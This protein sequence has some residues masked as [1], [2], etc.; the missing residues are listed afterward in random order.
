MKFAVLVSLFCS[1]AIA[2]EV[3]QVLKPGGETAPVKKRLADGS[4]LIPGGSRIP[5]T[6]LNSVS[7]KNTQPGDQ[8][9]LQTLVPIAI[10]NR[11][12]IPA[13]SYV[14]GTITDS[15]RPGKVK[16]RGEIGMRFD[17]MLL[18][19]GTTLNLTGRIGSLDGDNGGTLKRDEGTVKSGGSEAKDAAI[20]G[21]AA[22]AGTGMGRWIGDSGSSAGIGAGAAGAAGL[23]AVLLTR[24]PDAVLQKGQTVDMVLTTDMIIPTDR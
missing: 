19:S 17:S 24:G 16:G 8:I 1:F 23:A 12:V 6:V 15:K 7:S 9:Y 10:E 20:I 13:G 4:Y 3:R 22:A 14:T 21:T 2:Q 11:I 5:L 18:A